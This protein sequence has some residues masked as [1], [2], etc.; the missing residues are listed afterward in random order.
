LARIPRIRRA[1]TYFL[2][3]PALGRSAGTVG[4]EMVRKVLL[5]KFKARSDDVTCTTPHLLAPFGCQVKYTG[6]GLLLSRFS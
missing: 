5:E 6:E 1:S 3:A 4:T 2:R